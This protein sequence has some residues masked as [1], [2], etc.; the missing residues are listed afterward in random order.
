MISILLVTAFYFFIC[1]ISFSE[2]IHHG[3]QGREAIDDIIEKLAEEDP[4]FMEVNFEKFPR[5]SIRRLGRLL[6]DSQSVRKRS[7]VSFY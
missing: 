3:K 7:C 4:E 6:P 1:S 5:L 2:T